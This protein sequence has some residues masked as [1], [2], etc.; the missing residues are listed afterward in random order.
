MRPLLRSRARHPVGTSVVQVQIR[1][2]LP[3]SG[4][5][6]GWP[7]PP[8]KSGP[9]FSRDQHEAVSFVQRGVRVLLDRCHLQ[10][11]DVPRPETLLRTD[12]EDAMFDTE[13]K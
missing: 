9:L 8:R 2:P 10:A 11:T 1:V 7:G 4:A 5:V 12:D 6:P 3:C 13:R